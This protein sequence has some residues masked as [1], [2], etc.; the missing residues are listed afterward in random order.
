MKKTI[1][2]GL[3][4][5]LTACSTSSNYS[6]QWAGQVIDNIAGVGQG[7]LTFSQD[8]DTL[9]GAWQITFARGVNSGY[10]EGVVNGN[11]IRAQL[12]PSNPQACP[13]NVTATRS[14]DN[15]TG[16]YAAFNCNVANSGTITASRQ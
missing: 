4:I 11:S 1:L 8:G 15:L 12:Y 2:L 10:V 9:S 14:G 13:Y 5:V 6:G 3:L 7:N 16:N